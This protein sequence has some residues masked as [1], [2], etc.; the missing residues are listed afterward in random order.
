MP[1]ARHPVR[2]PG[3]ASRRARGA[4]L[5]LSVVNRGAT[6]W[7]ETGSETVQW[8]VSRSN[9]RPRRAGRE[10]A[11]RAYRCQ[12]GAAVEAMPRLVAGQIGRGGVYDA[13]STTT[14]T[15]LIG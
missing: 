3:G 11:E 5:A 10:R 13:F 15:P 14:V 12:A 8:T 6:A 9:A 1:V 4:R 2:L 7:G